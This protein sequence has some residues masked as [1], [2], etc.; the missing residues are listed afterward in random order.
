MI[1]TVDEVG[2]G[3]R[4]LRSQWPVSRRAER[5]GEQLGKA[6][7]NLV[8]VLVVTA[9]NPLPQAGLG[10]LWAEV[11]ASRGGIH[12][13]QSSTGLHDMHVGANACE[14]TKGFILLQ[15]DSL[16]GNTR[17]LQQRL[18]VAR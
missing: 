11:G 14:Q 3:F 7:N 13:L 18:K 1:R 12:K 9:I 8:H 5:P 15:Y 4:N 10:Y 17:E 16:A 6:P 2:A